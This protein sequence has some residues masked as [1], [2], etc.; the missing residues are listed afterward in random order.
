MVYSIGCVILVG[1]RLVY[2]LTHHESMSMIDMYSLL[3]IGFRILQS[4]LA[5]VEGTVRVRDRVR[6]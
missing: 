2:K 1:S 3:E 4:Y 5:C 6:L